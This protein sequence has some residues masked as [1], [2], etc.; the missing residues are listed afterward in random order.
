MILEP[1]STKNKV[2]YRCPSN[3]ALVK[4]WGKKE[5]GPQLPANPSISLTLSDLCAVTSVEIAYG[6]VSGQPSFSF[7]LEGQHKPSFEPKI[8][9]FLQKIWAYSLLVQH[10]T[11]AVS[12]ANNFPHGTGIA[13]SAAGFGALACCIAR[14]EKEHY[15]AYPG[16]FDS[17]ERSASFMARLGSGSACRSLFAAPAIWGEHEEFNSSDLYAVPFETEVHPD[18]ASLMDAVLIVD[19]GEKSVSSTA[20]HALLKGNEYAKVRYEVAKSN[21]GKITDAM[22]SGKVRAFINIVESEALQLHAMMMASSP[23][24][25]LMRPGTV[26]IIEKI[27]AYREKTGHP[28]MF[29]LDAGANVHLLFPHL[30]KQEVTNFIETE[31]LVY[32]QNKQYLCTRTGTAP[33]QC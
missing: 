29:T 19:A 7:L 17:F 15:G 6:N 23:Y 26:A 28:V 16:G 5:G 9:Q 4:Y 11:L 33:E 30:L 1:V 32:C 12:S 3:I 18:L 10:N 20:G 24:Y 13:S 2:T 27:W 22:T 14:L 25:L 8:L 31:L 21:L